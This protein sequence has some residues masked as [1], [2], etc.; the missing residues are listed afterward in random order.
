MLDV[1]RSSF[2]YEAVGDSRLADVVITHS[3]GTSEGPGS[4][5]YELGQFAAEHAAGRPIIADAVLA[6]NLP[7][8]VNLVHVV[9]GPVT[10]ISEKGVEGVGTWG[11]LEAAEKHMRKEGWTRAMQVA[12]SGHVGRVAMQATKAGIKNSI[13][14]PGLPGNF[15]RESAQIWTRNRGFWV[16]GNT[17]GSLMLRRRVQI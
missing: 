14:P 17:L 16:V 5:N 4:P 8:G 13:L 3:F 7:K 10:N 6:R 1:F 12:H 15:D 9:E 2:G 11:V